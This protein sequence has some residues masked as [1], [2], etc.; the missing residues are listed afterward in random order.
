MKIIVVH[1]I[2]EIKVDP[3]KKHAI[4]DFSDAGEVGYKYGYTPE[5]VQDATP[6]VWD[7][8]ICT[9]RLNGR[10][11]RELWDEE[12]DTDGNLVI[13][14]DSLTMNKIHRFEA[15]ARAYGACSLGKTLQTLCNYLQS[16]QYQELWVVC[17]KLMATPLGEAIETIKKL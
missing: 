15:T 8:L 17:S 7:A 11:Y 2:A 13:F 14:N 12:L 1:E 9:N 5:T 16:K 4:V 10:S 3:T 6:R